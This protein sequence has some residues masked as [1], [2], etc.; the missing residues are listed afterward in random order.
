MFN[1]IEGLEIHH[2][3]DEHINVQLVMYLPLVSVDT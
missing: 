2:N 3:S 1:I